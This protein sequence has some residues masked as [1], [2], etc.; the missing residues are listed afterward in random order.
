MRLVLQRVASALVSVD[1]ET[2]ASIGKGL[3]LLVG[4]EHDD[5]QEDVAA[6][7][8]KVADLRIFRDAEGKMNLSILDVSG[9]AMVV[10]Q[11]TLLADTS[12]GRRPSFVQAARPEIAEPL[13]ESLAE[14]L[15]GLGI[16]TST[17][18]FGA[19]MQVELVNDGPVTIVM[20][21]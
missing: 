20:D 19:N 1:D 21:A 3:L 15:R 17:G 9:E 7:A 14:A 6:A 11:F 13:V 5:G 4:I 16:S 18:R 8:R 10:S 12:R 2:I